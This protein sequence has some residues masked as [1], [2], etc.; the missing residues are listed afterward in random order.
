M[1]SGAHACGAYVDCRLKSHHVAGYVAVHFRSLVVEA[2]LLVARS[3]V[4]DAT[5]P[6]ANLH[7]GVCGCCDSC[8]HCRLSSLDCVFFADSVVEV[9]QTI[10]FHHDGLDSGYD[11]CCD[12]RWSSSGCVVSSR[13]GLGVEADCGCSS[14]FS[15]SL[16]DCL[17]SEADSCFLTLLVACSY[18]CHRTDPC[19]LLHLLVRRI[20][21]RGSFSCRLVLPRHSL[22]SLC[23]VEA[24]FHI[25]LLAAASEADHHHD[26]GVVH[27][28]CWAV[29]SL[30]ADSC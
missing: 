23:L 9:S 15:F 26:A 29:A 18:P 17:P 7:G 10:S 25:L 4:V 20:L 5:P 30:A 1:L 13:H 22:A 24:A 12:S 16:V 28:I 27:R 8:P 6:L 2:N 3:L 21:A 14:G 19:N 11:S